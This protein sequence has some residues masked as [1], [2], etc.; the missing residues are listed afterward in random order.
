MFAVSG[1]PVAVGKVEAMINAYLHRCSG[2]SSYAGLDSCHD[3]LLARIDEMRKIRKDEP[4]RTWVQ[5]SPW[6]RIVGRIII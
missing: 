6:D 2:I 5:R 4:K 3:L 1:P